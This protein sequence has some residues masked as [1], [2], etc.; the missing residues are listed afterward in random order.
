MSKSKVLVLHTSVGG[1]IRATAENVAEQL[2]NSGQFEV[3]VE[4]IE[5]VEQGVTTSMI[6][7][8]YLNI[9][10][11]FSGLWGFLYD[12]KIVL[13]LTLPLRKFIAK[14]KS[15]RILQILREFQPAIV[16]STSVNSSAIIAYLKSKGLYRGQ[17]VIVFSDYH[18]HRFWVH[19]EADLFLCNIPEQVVGLKKLGFDESKIRLTGTLVAAKFFHV[20]S[21]EEALST[22]GLL[23]TMPVVL[24]GGAGRA[25]NFTK[26]IF[27]Q[28]LR[29]PKSFQVAVICGRN[30]ELKEELQKI[31]APSRHPVKI[32]GYVDNMEIW[33]A[34]ARVLVYKTGGPSM[35]EAVIK[36]LPIIFS[37]VRPG[38]ELKNL[39]YLVGHGIGQYARIPREAV[40]MVE[41]ILDG[42]LN[43]NH[44]KNL[45]TLVR[46]AGAVS[47]VAAINSINP[48][49][50]SWAVK[51][52]QET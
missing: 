51:N 26:D 46:P 32:L 14:F 7:K 27:L 4:D 42:K 9:L 3:R 38:H 43:I 35:A 40:F 44:D 25:R 19:Q 1:G 23:T 16:I 15:K 11:H 10:D 6:R 33:M 21:R 34:A 41:Q 22:L 5:Q 47:V 2:T 28:L 29:S 13:F 24:V 8:T 52:Y 12:S 50:G 18:L 20:I 49:A 45:T 39:Q 36:K 37:D 31:S 48:E 17:F 30:Q